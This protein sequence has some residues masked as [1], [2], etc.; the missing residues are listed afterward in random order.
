MLIGPRV[1]SLA[2][3]FKR[4]GLQVHTVVDGDD[5]LLGEQPFDAGAYLVESPQ[6]EG[7]SALDVLRLLRKRSDAP[8]LLATD[9][10]G[11]ECATAFQHGAD[12]VLPLNMPA[13]VWPAALGSL[14]RR[15]S[16]AGESPSRWHFD[17]AKRELVAPD[18]AHITLGPTDVR[19][20][21][22]FAQA[23][24]EP[25]TREALRDAVWPAEGEVSTAEPLS[26]DVI[27]AL[28]AAIY[29]L[30]RRIESASEAVAPLQSLA[31][32]GY[33]FKGRLESLT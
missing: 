6:P 28:H 33:V 30:R 1:A 5:W 23:R 19:L 3:V 18:G 10:L 11:A 21:T 20:L 8:A 27:G 15:L 13:A 12:L 29:R 32:R 7:L 16:R 24:G 14:L 31:N 22:C 26:S 2:G 9:N 25:V 17:S 4:A